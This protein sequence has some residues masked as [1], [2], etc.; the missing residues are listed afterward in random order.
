MVTVPAIVS[1]PRARVIVEFASAGAKVTV[2]LLPKVPDGTQAPCATPSLNDAS[3]LRR[4][5][6]L[7]WKLS[8]AL[9]TVIVAAVAFVA[10][11]ASAMA[12]A[13]AVLRLRERC[14]HASIH[15]V[16]GCK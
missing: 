1:S 13:R 10:A 16:T 3:A 9:A 15:T 5:H 11:K 7:A 8:S 4:L 6:V 12:A 14:I 2:S